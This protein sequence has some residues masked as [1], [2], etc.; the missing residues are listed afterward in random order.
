MFKNCQGAESQPESPRKM[1]SNLQISVTMK[2]TQPT[3]QKNKAQDL[4]EQALWALKANGSPGQIAAVTVCDEVLATLSKMEETLV[5]EIQAG[6][7]EIGKQI[8][9]EQ[10]MPNTPERIMLELVTDSTKGLTQAISETFE[11]HRS[12]IQFQR[13][14]F[15]LGKIKIVEISATS[16]EA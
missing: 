15:A 6:L 1:G 8:A 13:N 3:D 5:K 9:A 12:I 14:R 10:T 7:I 2:K 16:K 11:L 4:V